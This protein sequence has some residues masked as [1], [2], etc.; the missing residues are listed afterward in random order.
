MY[1]KVISFW[2]SEVAPRQ[3]WQKD[4]AFDAAIRQRF[5]S[6]HKQATAGELADWRDTASGSLA[7]VIILDQFSRNIY[8]DCPEAFAND[9]QA[10]TL[11]QTTIA[12]GWDAELPSDQR[13]FLYM[14]FMHSESALIHQQAV[15]LFESLEDTT[16]LNFELKH[17]AIIDRFGRYPH[18]NKIL[19]RESSTEEAEFLM[20]PGSGF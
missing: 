5:G 18:R 11:A 6:L 16:Y 19:G 1:T 12:K 20:Q 9:A 13:A 3:W 17:K 14:P 8:R 4:K 15:R 7:E 2:F 10:L